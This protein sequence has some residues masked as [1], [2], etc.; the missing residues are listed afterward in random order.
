MLECHARAATA[1]I[2]AT[3]EL[4]AVRVR[5]SPATLFQV[6]RADLKIN[7]AVYLPTSGHRDNTVMKRPVCMSQRGAAAATRD[8]CACS[9]KKRVFILR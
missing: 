2:S 4:S 8:W 6:Q 1:I 7:D 3:S 5:T 9:L